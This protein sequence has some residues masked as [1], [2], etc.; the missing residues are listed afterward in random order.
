MF[1]RAARERR[2]QNQRAGQ[3]TLTVESLETRRL[4]TAVDFTDRDQLLLELVNR[5]RANPLAE[6]ARFG[7]DLNE[8]LDEGTITEEPKQPLAPNQALT[9]A[10]RGHS[11][12]MLDRGF[13]AHDNPDGLDPTA[14]AKAQGY[15][16]SAGE[17]IAWYGASR[18]LEKNEE[19]Y[20][21]HEALFLSESHRTNILNGGFRELGNG[22]KFGM[23]E[24][25]VTIMVTENFGNRGG[26]YFITGVAYDDTVERDNFYTMQEGLG[27]ITVTA[28][29][30]R[31]GLTV[32]T[33]TGEAGG[34][35]LEVPTGVYTVTARG[36][37]ISGLYSVNDVVVLGANQKVD[38]NTRVRGLGAIEGIVFDD[39]DRDGIRDAN[40]QLLAGQTVYLD[41]D[42]SEDRSPDE[43]STL[44]DANGVYRFS[45]LRS[46]DYVVVADTQAGWTATDTSLPVTLAPG[47]TRSGLHFGVQLENPAPIARDDTATTE[48]GRPVRIDVFAN[49]SD[50]GTLN[51]EET[52]IF[53]Q[54][55]HGI[56]QFDSPNAQLIY[57]PDAG[58]VG[59]DFFEYSVRDDAGLPSNVA[60]VDIHVTAGMSNPWQN[61]T[62]SNDVNNDSHLSPLDALLVLNDLNALGARSL[63]APSSGFDPPPYLDV[64]GDSF[65]T[66]VDAL[67]VLNELNRLAAQ[68]R[69]EAA[70][71]G[72]SDFSELAAAIEADRKLRSAS[73]S[74]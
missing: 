23:F 66:P 10:A 42:D 24:N 26:D 18:F 73:M 20:R 54:P 61:P 31:D 40:E 67:L 30:S 63:P 11:Q 41:A 35:G 37:G 22:I 43:T 51:P 70:A 50:D 49:D 19:V 15:S 27:S 65:V 56:V 1:S 48:E 38:F 14:R 68:E 59:T 62:I 2:R 3:R 45:N 46:G 36:P 29:R 21:R 7:I 13:F 44:T 47:Q 39:L 12:D 60:R 17:N 69:Q 52:R 53:T 9:N 4:L 28:T 74:I 55:E 8:G 32:S 34:Y 64:N 58:F 57:T 16:A 33:T 6:S 5:A 71:A 72:E 25:L